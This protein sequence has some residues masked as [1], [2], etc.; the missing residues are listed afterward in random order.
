[1]KGLRIVMALSLLSAFA[2]AEDNEVDLGQGRI[3]WV[4]AGE[5]APFTGSLYDKIA[6]ANLL[7]RLNTAEE[8]C[9][10]EIERQVGI[11]MTNAQLRFDIL[12]AQYEGLKLRTEAQLAARNDIIK[13]QQ[14]QLGRTRRPK[15]ELLFAAGVGTGIALTVLS[16]W[17]IGQAA[18]AANN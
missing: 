2:H 12:E 7:A 5:P 14:D 3:T 16:A 1:M 11:S 13:L 18:N 8:A 6:S 4:E 9:A 15:G 17:A 10:I